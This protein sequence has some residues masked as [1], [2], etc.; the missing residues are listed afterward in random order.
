MAANAARDTLYRDDTASAH[1][2]RMKSLPVWTPTALQEKENAKQIAAVVEEGYGGGDDA[3]SAGEGPKAFLGAMAP[4]P[5]GSGGASSGDVGGG[6]MVEGGSSHDVETSATGRGGGCGGG[7]CGDDGSSGS[8]CGGG[9]GGGG[10]GGGGGGGGSGGGGLEYLCL[11]TTADYAVGAV[12]L[13]QSLALVGSRATL[14]AIAT[15]TEAAEALAV[16]LAACPASSDDDDDDDDDNENDYDLHSGEAAACASAPPRPQRPP[17]QRPPR[18]RLVIELR[19]T[20][21]P[22]AHAAHGVTHGGKGAVLSVDA[23]R[24]RLWADHPEG[25]VLLDADLLAVSNP[26]PYFERFFHRPDQQQRPSCACSEVE[27]GERQNQH[28][29]GTAAVAAA[30]APGEAAPAAV[31]A[32]AN[33]R[34][35]KKA[36]GCL[37]SGGG[38]GG[39]GWGK[40]CNFNAGV[41]V[42]PGP[43]DPAEGKALEALVRRAASDPHADTTEELLLNELFEVRHKRNFEFRCVFL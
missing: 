4:D 12:C 35:K 28:Q 31:H 17:L 34:L 40:G 33:F 5:A 29:Q 36:F 21:L 16:E 43:A 3:K 1:S 26:D 7:R 22:A 37:P 8:G 25:F 11:V 6:A 2:F 27:R 41:M 32:V 20:A 23:P 13:A 38:S 18:P 39:G 15:S 9:C 24:R 42:V 30:A 14:R 10:D 19:K